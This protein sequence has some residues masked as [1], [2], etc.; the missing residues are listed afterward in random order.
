MQGNAFTEPGTPHYDFH[1]SMETWWDQYRAGG[2]LFQ[3]TPT[4]GQYLQ[5]L[6]QA[7]EAGGYSPSDAANLAAQAG[8]QQAAYGLSP[9]APVPRIPGPI[10]QVQP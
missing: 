8:A 2:Q 4:N 7:L 9:S 3:Q 6:Q 10:Y 1:Q 5:A